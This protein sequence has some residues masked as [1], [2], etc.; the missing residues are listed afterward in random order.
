MSRP[1]IRISALGGC[2]ALL[3]A[4]A[5]G[6]LAQYTGR[7]GTVSEAPKVAQPKKPYPK[8]PY[9]PPKPG[10]ARAPECAWT[11]QRLVSVLLRDDVLAARGFLE[12][13]NSFDCPTAHLGRAFGCAIPAAGNGAEAVQRQIESCWKDPDYIAE[14]AVEKKPTE[15]KPKTTGPPDKAPPAK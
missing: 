13:Y 3:L 2:L 9:P 10:T 7:T 14:P 15:E 11:G 5:P 12:F 8:P 4:A 1:L 6:T